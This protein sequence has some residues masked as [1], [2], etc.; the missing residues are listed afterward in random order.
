DHALADDPNFAAIVTTANEDGAVIRQR[1]FAVWGDAMTQGHAEHLQRAAAVLNAP[2]PSLQDLLWSARE[3]K[4]IA[5]RAGEVNIRCEYELGQLLRDIRQHYQDLGQYIVGLA[6]ALRDAQAVIPG[7]RF[8][9][10]MR[11]E[12]HMDTGTAHDFIRRADCDPAGV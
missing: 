3:G 7:E 5:D 1:E 9:V 8:E 6:Q 11:T 4:R 12:L 2:S 10:Y